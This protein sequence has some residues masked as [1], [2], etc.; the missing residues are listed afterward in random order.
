M[1]N[2]TERQQEVLSFISQF[3]ESHAY[4]PTVREIAERFSISV[5]GAYDHMK[6]LEKKGA[7]RVEGNRSRAVE[8]VDRRPRSDSTVDV[9]LMGEVAAGKPLFA[10]ENRERNVTVPAAMAGSRPCFALRVRGDSMRD[11]GILNGDIALIEERPTAEDGEIVVAMVDESVTLKRF[12][13]ENNRIRLQAENPSFP[14]IYTQ[15]ARILGR[16]KGLLRTYA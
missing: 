10:E 16:L 4:P 6:A 13:R 1:K 5:K 12:F 9:P 15:E 11:A 2:L 14:P 7:L 8:V 3:V